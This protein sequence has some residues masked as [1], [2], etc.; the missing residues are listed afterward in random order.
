MTQF[1]DEPGP[2]LTPQG[3][4]PRVGTHA[5][6]AAVAAAKDS[7]C[8]VSGALPPGFWTVFRE[9]RPVPALAEARLQPTSD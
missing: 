2:T 3:G 9:L 5:L 6:P 7:R 8:P 1:R 4:R